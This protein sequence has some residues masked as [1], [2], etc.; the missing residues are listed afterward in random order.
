MWAT[1]SPL[2]DELLNFNNVN[3]NNLVFKEKKNQDKPWLDLT[4]NDLKKR[5]IK[6]N[7]DLILQSMI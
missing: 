7:Y 3:V 5:K 2:T 6:I 1:Y 4:V